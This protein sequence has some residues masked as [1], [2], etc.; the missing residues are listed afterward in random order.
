MKSGVRSPSWSVRAY[1]RGVKTGRSQRFRQPARIGPA[2]AG[3]TLG[4]A[5]LGGSLLVYYAWIQAHAP[6]LSLWMELVTGEQWLDAATTA[7]MT[8]VVLGLC[9]GAYLAYRALRAGETVRG[10]AL[11]RDLHGRY[12]DAAAQLGHPDA[13]VRLS[14]S[15]AMA[16]LADDWHRA[17]DDDQRQVAVNVLTA[18]YRSPLQTLRGSADPDA[19][20]GEVRSIIIRLVAARAGQDPSADTSWAACIFDLTGANLIGVELKGAR[21][22]GALLAGANLTYANLAGADLTRADLTGADL[23][24][25]DL[26]G[27]KLVG[28]YL[29]GANLIGADLKDV[30]LRG[31]VQN[32]TTRWPDGFK[33][34]G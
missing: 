8:L 7:A 26:T 9:G 24:R 4:G 31:V 3:W 34:A 11:R 13:A 1:D 16:A 33:A 27:A 6:F 32:V 18:Y 20:E 19:R 21:L 5:V 29:S 10:D 28:A 25:A 15:Y 30:D 17:G 14:G 12:A 23:A 2:L 22:G